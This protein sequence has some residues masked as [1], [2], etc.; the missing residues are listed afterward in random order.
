MIYLV[1]SNPGKLKEFQ[2]LFSSKKI[3]LINEIVPKFPEIEETGTTYEENALLKIKAFSKL[4]VPLLADDSGLEVLC[5]NGKPGVL[6]ARYGG[7][8]SQSEKNKKLLEEA[9]TKDRNPKAKFVCVLAYKDDS[10]EFFVRGECEGFLGD[11]EGEKGF[12]YDPIFYPKEFPSKSFAN[13][14]QNEKNQ[15]SHRG[16]AV[17][18][19]LK[20]L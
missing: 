8:I 16:R 3:S 12:G 14:S 2:S 6:T 18:E 4:N 1:S 19:L 15:I 10:K 7:N 5:L 11:P 13:L 17:Q 9:K 20:K